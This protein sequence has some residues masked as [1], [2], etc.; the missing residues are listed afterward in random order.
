MRIEFH[1][2]VRDRIPEIIDDEGLKYSIRTLNQSEY[3]IALLEK[4]VE[5]ASEAAGGQ[6]ADLPQELADIFELI[7]AIMLE[8]GIME[9]TVEE[10]QEE[11]RRQRGGFS[12][13]IQLL[14]IED[15]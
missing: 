11:K 7:N 5:E 13:R 9:S 10:I 14:W 1:K 4:L 12:K 3:R 15:R 8:F 6:E 2:L